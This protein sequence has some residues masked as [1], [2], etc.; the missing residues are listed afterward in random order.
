MCVQCGGGNGVTQLLL[1]SIPHFKELIIAAFECPDC[2]YQ[3]NSVES[4]HQIADKGLKFTLTVDNQ[5]DL[6]RRVVKGEHA[7]VAVIVDKN[8]QEALIEIP[9]GTQK[10][11]LNTVEG[12]LV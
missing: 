2:N 3:N 10:G 5:H 11:T 4:A 12:L 9:A 7:T 1:T 8:D 6:N